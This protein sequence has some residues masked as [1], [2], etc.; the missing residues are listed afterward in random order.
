MKA[1]GLWTVLFSETAEII[2]NIPVAEQINRGG[3]LVLINGKIYGGGI[4]Y[5]YA[6]TY[7][8]DDSTISMTIQVKKYNDLVPGIFGISEGAMFV[9]FGTVDGDDMKLHGHPED[10]KAKLIF[11]KAHRQIDID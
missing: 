4:S 3:T 7:E 9:L 5:Y 10:D 6:G 11:I 1:D 2:E 8:Y